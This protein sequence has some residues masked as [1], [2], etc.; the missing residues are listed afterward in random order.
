[1][2]VDV[3]KCFHFI[4]FSLGLYLVSSS[5]YLL[6]KCIFSSQ[7]CCLEFILVSFQTYLFLFPALSLPQ[8]PVFAPLHPIIFSFPFHCPC[9]SLSPQQ[10]KESP[11]SNFSNI[12]PET[13]QLLLCPLAKVFC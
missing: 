2:V 4:D 3:L 5:V 1:M 10:N 13:F 8:C 12:L 9:V 11:T 7:F 6:N